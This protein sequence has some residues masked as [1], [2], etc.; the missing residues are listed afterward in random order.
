MAAQTL[1]TPEPATNQSLQNDRV[2]D[3]RKV[4]LDVVSQLSKR[5]HFGHLGGIHKCGDNK[6]CDPQGVD[7]INHPVRIYANKPEQAI[8]PN[9]NRRTKSTVGKVVTPGGKNAGT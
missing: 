3:I 7:T 1:A 6:G 8:K 2:G 5:T 4:V 9:S